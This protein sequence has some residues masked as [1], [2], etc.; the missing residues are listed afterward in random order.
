MKRKLLGTILMSSLLVLASCGEAKQSQPQGDSTPNQSSPQDSSYSDNG[1]SYIDQIERPD[2]DT[3][4][5]IGGY[6]SLP[7]KID[8][9]QQGGEEPSIAQYKVGGTKYQLNEE[10]EHPAFAYQD[11]D[12]WSYIYATVQ[13]YDPEYCNFRITLHAQG[14]EKIA[15]QAIYEEIYTENCT[16]VTVYT[17]DVMDGDQYI[18]AR[19]GQYKAN[20]SIY[21]PIS[22]KPLK[23]C[24]ILGFTILVDS[25]PAQKVTD[26]DGEVRFDEFVFM[27]DGDERIKD[28]H[29]IPRVNFNNAAGDPGYNTEKQGDEFHIE[30]DNIPIYSRVYLP[31]SSASPDYCEFEITL[32]TKGVSSYSIGVMYSTEGHSDWDDQASLLTVENVEDGVHTHSVNYESVSPINNQSWEYVAGELIKNHNVYQIVIWLDSMRDPSDTASYSGEATVK[33]VEF[34]RTATEGC[35]IGKAWSATTSSI[36]VNDDVIVGGSGSI[37]YSFFQGWFYLSIPVAGYKPNTHLTMQV[38]GDISY[39]G[40]ELVAGGNAVTILSGWEKLALRDHET[41]ESESQ[42]RGSVINITKDNKGIYTLEWDF[43]NAHKSDISGMAFYEDTITA[44]RFYLGDP[45]TPA[46]EWD[47]TRTIKFVSIAFSE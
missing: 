24:K 14:A 27:K 42:A 12:D 29:I 28:V 2:I 46:E 43:T 25:N 9:V 20:N 26:K 3:P 45:N 17:G 7:E 41:D 34:I 4:V 23:D 35:V 37:D 21:E 13:D 5:V 15:I 22:D 39:F 38:M 10:E 19:L 47:G 33:N 8:Y 44:I 40:I 18:L 36:T 11:V 6:V 1:F 30:Y 32:D 16:P 31:I